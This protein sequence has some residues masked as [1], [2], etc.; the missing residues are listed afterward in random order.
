[1]YGIRRCWRCLTVMLCGLDSECDKTVSVLL[2]GLETTLSFVELPL[3]VQQVYI[4]QRHLMLSTHCRRT[5]LSFYPAHTAVSV[6]YSP[7]SVQ[8]THKH[9]VTNSCAWSREEYRCIFVNHDGIL[10]DTA[11]EIFP[12]DIFPRRYP[13][14]ILLPERKSPEVTFPECSNIL[15][16]RIWKLVLTRTPDPIRPTRRCPDPHGRY[17]RAI[18]SRGY[19]QGGCL[20]RGVC[21]YLTMTIMIISRSRLLLHGGRVLFYSASCASVR[22]FPKMARFT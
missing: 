12:L 7:T 15:E 20:H 6:V 18:F 3:P 8:S 9:A 16:T 5:R 22:P 4:R 14:R 2:D 21:G 10:G 17:L 11:T 19:S 13:P 1:M